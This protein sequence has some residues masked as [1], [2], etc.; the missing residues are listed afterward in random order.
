MEFMDS[1]RRDESLASAPRLQTPAVLNQIASLDEVHSGNADMPTSPESP[2]GS[3]SQHSEAW[4]AGMR[5]FKTVKHVIKHWELVQ[6]SPAIGDIPMTRLMKACAKDSL[7]VVLALLSDLEQENMSVLT[8]ELHAKDSWAGSSPLHWAAFSGNAAIARALL[9]AGANPLATNDRDES[10]PMHLAARYGAAAVIEALAEHAPSSLLVKRKGGFTP[11]HEAAAEGKVGALKKLLQIA[12]KVSKASARSSTLDGVVTRAALLGART[13]SDLGGYTPLLSAIE[14]GRTD[15]ISVLLEHGADPSIEAVVGGAVAALEATSFK[16]KAGVAPIASRRFLF[17]HLSMSSVSGVAAAATGASASA[18]TPM[19]PED[20][21]V[22]SKFRIPGHGALSLALSAGHLDVVEQLLTSAAVG[23]E[24]RFPAV[25][26]LVQLKHI[27]VEIWANAQLHSSS[28]ADRLRTA[29]LLTVLVLCAK[30]QPVEPGLVTPHADNAPT[31]SADAAEPEPLDT[32]LR[33]NE[34]DD[35]ESGGGSP[36]AEVATDNVS[37]PQNPVLV[38]LKLAAECEKAQR[39]V[40]RDRLRVT[41]LKDGAMLLEF[42]ACGLL[43]AADRAVS[44]SETTK[45]FNPWRMGTK[46]ILPQTARDLFVHESIDFA[47]RHDLKIF[48][49]H[50]IVYGHLQEVFWP[51]LLRRRPARGQGHLGGS[52]YSFAFYAGTAFLNLASLPLLPFIPNGWE[53]DLEEYCRNGQPTHASST[54]P[55]A[56][57]LI[58]LWLLPVGRFALWFGSTLG[59]AQLATSIPPLSPELGSYDLALLAY[60]IGWVKA[61]ADE[62]RRATLRGEGLRGYATNAFNVLDALICILLALLLV[63]RRAQAFDPQGALNPTG[64]IAPLVLPCQALLALIASIRLMQVL[65]IFATSGPLL[66]MSIR[67]LEDL[68]QFLT[69]AGFVVLAFACSFYVLFSHQIATQAIKSTHIIRRYGDGDAADIGAA[70]VGGSSH[71]MAVGPPGDLS[72]AAV[73]GL[74]VTASMKG[75]PDQIL[76]GHLMQP[77]SWAV[78]FLF[79]LVVVLLLLNLLIARFAKTF[80]MV[81][82]NVD[83][84]F[85]VAFARVV[86]ECREKDLLPPPLNILRVLINSMRLGIMQLVQKGVNACMPSSRW[87]TLDNNSDDDDANDGPSPRRKPGI[88]VGAGGDEGTSGSGGYKETAYVA[89]QVREYLRRALDVGEPLP[90][91]VAAYVV[92]HQHDIGREDQWRTEFAKQ[93][94]LVTAQIGGVEAGFRADLASEM[95]TLRAEIKAEVRALESARRDQADGAALEAARR[96]ENSVRATTKVEAEGSLAPAKA[97][98]S[99]DERYDKLIEQLEAALPALL[100]HAAHSETLAARLDGRLRQL[101][102]SVESKLEEQQRALLERL[103]TS[104]ASG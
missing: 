87:K 12:D 93:I 24:S 26:S 55:A 34:N 11:L 66:I 64:P 54:A 25:F 50:P 103:I 74:L 47:A 85:K 5:K 39:V 53:F 10:L 84:N 58:L 59:L 41:K 70:S 67:M 68:W 89:Q 46:K 97:L 98:A 40:R 44:E 33:V 69:L 9:D 81:Y 8:A 28:A 18:G 102:Q 79:G 96:A 4:M 2:P 75:E 3:S 91:Q 78:M 23:A 38:A 35:V 100:D 95:Q 32:R 45:G 17:R 101:E 86:I 48:V 72:L 22:R 6:I 63:G 77:F 76:D 49:S 51:T 21:A 57:P 62:L 31:E 19:E 104:P 83:A 1:P 13:D 71:S 27:I 90:A 16:V 61:E 82:E 99:R 88:G 80:D 65:F 37:K 36:P 60:L 42:V 52:G 56:P 94:G 92:R 29:H 30:P 7:D 20:E 15:I 14:H 73:L 43:H